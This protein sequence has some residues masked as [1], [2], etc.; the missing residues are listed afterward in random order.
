MPEEKVIKVEV[1]HHLSP[2]TEQLVRD[3]TYDFIEE[4]SKTI[5]EFGR[6]F[7]SQF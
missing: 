6:M 4:F 3:V 2:E 1:E 7:S 5:E